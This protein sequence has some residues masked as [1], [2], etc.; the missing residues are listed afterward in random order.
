MAP[1]PVTHS[2]AF[3]LS[4][5]SQELSE[6][7]GQGARSKHP[8]GLVIV[9]AIQT[10]T[11]VY[12]SAPF[13]GRQMTERLPCHLGHISKRRAQGPSANRTR[14]I[15]PGPITSGCRHCLQN[16]TFHENNV[17]QPPRCQTSHQDLRILR[18]C[19]EAGWDGKDMRLSYPS[20]HRRPSTIQSGV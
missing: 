9:S 20:S 19:R 4:S 13:R 5:I 1:F 15:L 16:C 18:P 6:Q 7:P 12:S 17:G 10:Q 14:I 2:Q 11:A 8:N 3:A